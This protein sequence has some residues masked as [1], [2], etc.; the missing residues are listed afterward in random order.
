MT[1]T[2]PAPSVVSA[3]C[4][5]DGYTLLRTPS[6]TVARLRGHF[7]SVPADPY[8]P[9]GFRYKSIARVRLHRDRL[10]AGPHAGL[11]QS[12]DVN[13]THGGYV[14][15]YP[16]IPAGLLAELTGPVRLFH[17]AA[18]LAPGAEVLVQAQRIS[19]CAGPDGDAGQPAVEGFHQDDVDAVGILVVDRV[20]VRGGVSM[21]ST[22]PGVEE[23]AFA[24]LLEPGR[25]LVLDDRRLWHYTSSVRRVRAGVPAYRDVI[26]FGWPSSRPPSS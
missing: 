4:P 11:H 20:N 8:V 19:A 3:L 25:M 2:L 13:P 21:L 15:D 12:T 6:R 14:R 16:A 23:V 1:A 9:E 22:G 10:V 18:G 5:D 17:A 26:L 24:G 7:A